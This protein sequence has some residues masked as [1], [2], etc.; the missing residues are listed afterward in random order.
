[1]IPEQIAM[2]N[3]FPFTDDILLDLN[4]R[5]LKNNLIPGS[6]HFALLNFYLS[7]RNYDYYWYI[8]DDVIFNGKWSTFFNYNV[9]DHST[10]FRSCHIRTFQDEP[11]WAWWKTLNHP[12]YRISN[13]LLLRSFNPIFQISNNALSFLDFSLTSG[14]AGHYEVLIPTLLNLN[15]YIISDFGGSGQIARSSLTNKFYIDCVDDPS[16]IISDGTMRYRPE[17]SVDEISEVNKLYHP[18]KF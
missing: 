10:D 6:C 3:F 4:Y 15:G 18:V 2:T 1:V 12:Q 5:P 9:K 11:F 14:W 8:E 17:I 7:N 13:N 16:G